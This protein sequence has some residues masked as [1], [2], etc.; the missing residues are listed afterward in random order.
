MKVGQVAEW[1]D[2]RWQLRNVIEADA[3]Q[4]AALGLD[5]V[6]RV[7]ARY[8]MRLTPYA[9]AQLR[10]HEPDYPLNLLA[11]PDA[12]ELL[13]EPGMGADPFGERTIAAG[14]HGVKQ[15][16]PDRVLIMAH[17]QCAVNCRHCTR[18]GLLAATPLLRTLAQLEE[19]IA[20]VRA[21][22]LVREVI[23]SGGDPLLLDDQWL[24]QLVQAF[25]TLPQIDAVRLGTRVPVALPMRFTPQLCQALGRTGKVWVNTQ[26]NHVAEITPEARLA[27]KLL[28]E[29]GIPVSNQSVLLRGVNDASETLFA[30]CSTLQAI[31]VRPYYVFMCD[32][33]AGIAHFRVTL[34]R[35]REIENELATRLGGLALPRF[36]RDIPGAPRKVPL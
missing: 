16:F 9:W 7:C 30:L 18:K 27:C 13:D 31:R 12:R 24:L 32:P 8:P 20:W 10:P 35:A 1:G 34:E 17:D 2:W 4:L 5:M 29:A 6:R 26:F 11:L 3:P 15:R 19:V 14:P 25:A 33:I 21:R 22:P 23:L 28:V 36:V